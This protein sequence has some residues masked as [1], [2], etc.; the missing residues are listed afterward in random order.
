MT[1]LLKG[2]IIRQFKRRFARQKSFRFFVL[3]LILIGSTISSASLVALTISPQQAW[4][5]LPTAPTLATNPANGLITT[6]TTPTLDWNSASASPAVTSYHLL[7]DNNNDFLSPEFEASVL[8]P[9]TQR[10]TSTL[11]LAL[12]IGKFQQSILMVKAHSV[13][14]NN[15]SG[16]GCSYISISGK[17]RF[18]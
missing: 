2:G 3:S 18:N 16:F 15:Y 9:T 14:T 7:A 12:T 10:D 8:A 17:W 1:K 6:D 13:C 11:A 5:A 4:A